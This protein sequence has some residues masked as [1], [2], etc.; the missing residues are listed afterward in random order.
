[1]LYVTSV[2]HRL[3]GCDAHTPIILVPV[4][5]HAGT[6]AKVYHVYS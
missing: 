2:G 4:D 1:M 5:Y 6:M 3:T